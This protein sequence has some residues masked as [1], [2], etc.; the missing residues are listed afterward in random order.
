MKTFPLR[1]NANVFGVT[2][3]RPRRGPLSKTGKI[4]PRRT[5]S[6]LEKWDAFGTAMVE[7]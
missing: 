5:V 3:L 6:L 2:L 7:L 4:R 1:S